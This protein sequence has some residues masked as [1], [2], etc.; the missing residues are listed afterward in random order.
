MDELTELLREQR[1]VVA[2]LKATSKRMK[3][4]V[5]QNEFKKG[6]MVQHLLLLKIAESLIA[7]H[8]TAKI[9]DDGGTLDLIEDAMRHVGKRL[10]KET[11]YGRRF[12]RKHLWPV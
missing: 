12:D 3:A 10:A 7:A 1:V 8:K 6:P 4:T 5:R 9:D 11:G 2:A